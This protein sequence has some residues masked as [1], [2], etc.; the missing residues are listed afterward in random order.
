MVSFSVIQDP[1]PLLRPDG[2]ARLLRLRGWD[3]FLS[4]GGVEDFVAELSDGRVMYGA[5]VVTKKNTDISKIIFVLWVF[6]Y[7]SSKEN[8]SL[9][10]L[11]QKSIFTMNRSKS[12]LKW[13]IF[14]SGIS[15][16]PQCSNRRRSIRKFY[17]FSS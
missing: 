10:K 8:R 7:L 16:D 14:Y 9:P 15:F 11:S 13:R 2:G 3:Y 5:V 17:R 6:P 12:F 4:D 1:F